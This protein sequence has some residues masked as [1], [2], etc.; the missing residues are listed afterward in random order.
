MQRPLIT[1]RHAGHVIAPP[2]TPPPD[3]LF[4]R[5][6]IG[7]LA[8]FWWTDDDGNRT[9]HNV[10]TGYS[11][12]G[13]DPGKAI[14]RRAALQVRLWPE[15][16]DYVFHEHAGGARQL[17]H[18]DI[19]NRTHQPITHPHGIPGYPYAHT[20]G[21]FYW[22]ETDVDA[23]SQALIRWSFEAGPQVVAEAPFAGTGSWE[24]NGEA[25][26]DQVFVI[27]DPSPV[28][29]LVDYATGAVET[30]PRANFAA[31]TDSLGVPADPGADRLGNFEFGGSYTCPRI[32]GVG[33]GHIRGSYVS[34][35]SGFVSDLVV[36]SGS[37]ADDVIDPIARKHTAMHM[38][39]ARD[40]M[41]VYPFDGSGTT[42]DP[43]R[44]KLFDPS[45]TSSAPLNSNPN[46]GDAIPLPLIDGDM[47]TQPDQVWPWGE[48][49]P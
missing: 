14:A 1:L 10:E 39:A 22:R 34:S 48:V 31:K 46:E 11:S 2:D 30:R 49:A 41:L 25:A 40:R 26:H 27:A 17:H 36:V 15:R 33:S 20:D 29:H 45:E 13:Q 12:G 42:V 47:S 32:A 28:V 8:T 38:N 9:I 37:P 5:W 35:S 19:L 18:L 43:Y 7:T 24:A 23:G 44:A 6:P 16:L 4:L 21:S 3:E